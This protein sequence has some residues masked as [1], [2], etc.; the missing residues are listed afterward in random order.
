MFLIHLPSFACK[1]RL[2][3]RQAKHKRVTIGY[4]VIFYPNPAQAVHSI[5]NARP[6]VG[7]KIKANVK[8]PPM[9]CAR[10]ARQIN[11]IVSAAAVKS[12]L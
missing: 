12:R 4:L 11:L 5:D 1:I 10:Y 9:F 7:E 2:F 6:L 3:A 8:S